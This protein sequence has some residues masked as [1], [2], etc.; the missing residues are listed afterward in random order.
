[1]KVVIHKDGKLGT[2]KYSKDGQAM[3]SHPDA[4][5]R[6]DVKDYLDTEREFTVANPN[7]DPDVV[8][9]RRKLYASPKA[10]EDTMSMALCEMFHHTGVHVDWSGKLSK[11]FLGQKDKNSKA[12][13]PIEKSTVDDFDIIN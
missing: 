11:D 8:G 2:V 13:K 1:M 9:S 12:D 5:V 10:N 4:K 7:T 6:K 3:V